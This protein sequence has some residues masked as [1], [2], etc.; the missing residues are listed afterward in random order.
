MRIGWGLTGSVWK[1][2]WS[3]MQHPE[4]KRNLYTELFA[5][6]LQ[7]KQ[8]PVRNSCKTD[9][10][11]YFE[12][13]NLTFWGR[14]LVVRRFGHHSNSR[15]ADEIKG[16]PISIDFYNRNMELLLLFSIIS[17]CYNLKDLYKV[18]TKKK[19][20]F[21]FFGYSFKHLIKIAI[22][23][24]KSIHI[25]MFVKTAIDNITFLGLIISINVD[26]SQLVSFINIKSR[27]WFIRY[28]WLSM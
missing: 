18:I 4:I 2:R 23:Q 28:R 21:S 11:E 19:D 17:P 24:I 10:N 12:I 9:S 22:F 27:T 20:T 1:S 15:G 26:S 3:F 7:N 6:S 13:L 5:I 25:W 14:S 8:K 16:L